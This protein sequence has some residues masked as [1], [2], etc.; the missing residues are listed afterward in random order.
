MFEHTGIC[1]TFVVYVVE[2]AQSRGTLVWLGQSKGFVELL[3]DV[4]DA[5]VQ[6][7]MQV[8]FCMW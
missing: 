4:G 6:F 7:V 8:Q 2:W 5:W 3:L 1:C